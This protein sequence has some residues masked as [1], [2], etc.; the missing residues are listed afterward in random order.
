MRKPIVND[1]SEYWE[2]SILD[3]EARC[4][5]FGDFDGDGRLEIVTKLRWFR[6]ETH[7]RGEIEG[8]IPFDAVGVVAG[9]IDGDGRA[10]VVSVTL[11]DS[12]TER[13]SGE[14]YFF[15]LRW[16]KPTQDLS[17]PWECH[18]FCI[19]K[20][21]HP[22]DILIADVD[23]DG[24]NEIV[25][26]R[27]Y[28]ARPGVYIYRPGAD[29]RSPWIETVVQCGTSG[30]GT[31]IGDF[32]GDGKVEI[33]AGPFLYH[34]PEGGPFA[35]GWIQ[36]NL[37]PGLRDMCRATSIDITGDG[38]PNIVVAESEYPDCRVSWFEHSGGRWT[39]HA[40]DAPFDFIHSLDSWRESDGSVSVFLAEMN[41]GG[42]DAPYNHDARLV[43][44]NSRSRGESWTREILSQGYGTFQAFGVDVDGDGEREILG[45]PAITGTNV[46]VWKKRERP[47]FP[48]RYRHRFMDRVKPWT[49]T[50]LLVADVDGDGRQDVVCGAWWYRNPT[51][52]RY[53]IP[54][55]FQIINAYDIDGDGKLEFIATTAANTDSDYWYNKL[56]SE[57]YWVKPIDPLQGAWEMHYIGTAAGG[58]GTHGWPHGTT[59]APVLPGGQLAFIARG[60]GP[61]EL[62]QIPRDPKLLAEPWPKRIFTEAV[63]A[64]TRM[65]PVDLNGDGKLDLVAMWTWLENLGDG[66][67]RSHRITD[68]FDP[69]V[70]KHTGFRGGEHVVA[71]IDGNGLLDVIACE[72]NV[73]WTSRPQLSHFALLA[74]F[75]NPGDPTKGPWKRHAIDAIRSPHSLAVADL[76]GD[77]QLEIVCAEHDP[78]KVER[79]RPKMYVYK[80]DDP[81]GRSWTRHIVDDRFDNHVGAQLIA[82]G[83]GKTGIL[84]HGWIE[85]GVVHLWEPVDDPS[86]T[87]WLLP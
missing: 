30:D 45:A 40:L 70:E 54:D 39:E 32:D 65:V 27:M 36:T 51:W 81:Q 22:H 46:C 18:E 2:L 14:D 50:D 55:V 58:E 71:D 48:L 26:V 10:E 68:R 44:Y 25:V 17:E 1:S 29:I 47:S 15:S 4:A 74:W 78:F 59:I 64:D 33:V 28:I 85:C 41:Q 9:D 11:L 21:G 69:N 84:S 75:E 76:D 38:V 19:P 3:G 77:G 43:R 35:D 62:Y 34:S 61:I 13:K 87:S 66:T 57:L 20:R 42:W 6:P 12:P 37:A 83:D 31:T 67:F 7:D 80:R 16:Y 82:L 52:E 24:R 5:V 63:D 23:G 86:D 49:G 60:S 8:G 72:E 56:S 73:D 79:A 53:T